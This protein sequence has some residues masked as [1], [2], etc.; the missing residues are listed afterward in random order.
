MPDDPVQILQKALDETASHDPS[1]EA[2][3]KPMKRLVEVCD[4]GDKISKSLLR[5]ASDK[6]PPKTPTPV[7][8][9]A[10]VPPRQAPVSAKMFSQMADLRDE[11]DR[12]IPVFAKILEEIDALGKKRVEGEK[13]ITDWMRGI[14]PLVGLPEPKKPSLPIKLID[15]IDQKAL[16]FIRQAE[17]A[18]K[19]LGKVK[20]KLDPAKRDRAAAIRKVYDD[21]GYEEFGAAAAKWEDFKKEVL[22]VRKEMLASLVLEVGGL[23][24]PGTTVE[25]DL[26]DWGVGL[27][28]AQKL[29]DGYRDF[30]TAVAKS[31]VGE[32]FKAIAKDFTDLVASVDT[33]QPPFA[34]IESDSINVSPAFPSSLVV[35]R[36]DSFGHKHDDVLKGLGVPMTMPY[37]IDFPLADPLI[38]AD[39]ALIQMLV[40]RLAQALPQGL[41]EAYA[42]DSENVG[43]TFREIAGLRKLGILTVSSKADDDE[44]I[45]SELDTWLGDLS[46][47]GCWDDSTDWADYNRKHPEAPLPFKLVLFP[48]LSSLDAHRLSTVAKL[49]KNGAAAGVVTAFSE[50]ALDSLSEL[51]G[52]SAAQSLAEMTK[53]C[54][55]LETL[56]VG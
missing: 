50:T 25:Q 39:V 55:S 20:A 29:P 26:T 56:V 47:R 16:A 18:E 11:L 44:R 19:A 2:L 22:A 51:A 42:V 35:G 4:A 15:A 54:V 32:L 12:A 23:S 5:T 3:L 30:D 37:F 17:E 28:N 43:Q 6:K 41:F 10:N 21:A 52:E 38:Y 36:V 53:G 34:K 27:E 9:S 31:A 13:A 14:F 45:L 49:A 8:V 1:T 24:L 46:D 7:V 40:L 48:S 33:A